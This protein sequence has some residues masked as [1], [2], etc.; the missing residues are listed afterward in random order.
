MIVVAAAGSFFWANAGSRDQ[1]GVLLRI[2]TTVDLVVVIAGT[3][4]VTVTATIT[5]GK[6]HAAGHATVCC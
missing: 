4:T 5:F 2:S 3:G 6:H 1:H